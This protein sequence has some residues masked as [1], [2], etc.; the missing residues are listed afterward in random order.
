KADDVIRDLDSDAPERVRLLNAWGT[1]HLVEGAVTA[2][3]RELSQAVELSESIATPPDFG[4]ALHNLAGVEMQIGQLSHALIHETRA[5]AI[6]R[7][8][9]G[10]RHH[11]V[12]KALV[13]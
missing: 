11:Y 8:E 3:Q 5:L 10:E 12:L 2:A 7:R 1:I 6:L 13:S 9:F 4:A